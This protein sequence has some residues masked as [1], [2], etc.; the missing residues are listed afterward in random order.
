MNTRPS[1]SMPAPATW[2]T[3][4]IYPSGIKATGIAFVPRSSIKSVLRRARRAID[5]DGGGV[6]PI[7]WPGAHAGA[8]VVG[9]TRLLALNVR[10]RCVASVAR[11][12]GPLRRCFSRS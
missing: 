5:R 8:L 9:D 1:S 6:R 4:S 10:H 7:G 11:S 12:A 2:P 3:S